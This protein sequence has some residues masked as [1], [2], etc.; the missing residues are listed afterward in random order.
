LPAV[1]FREKVNAKVGKSRCSDRGVDTSRSP[2][3][4]LKSSF[5]DKNTLGSFRYIHRRKAIVS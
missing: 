4:F 2:H 1:H 3:M 5:E